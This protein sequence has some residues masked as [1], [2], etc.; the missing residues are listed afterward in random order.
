[1]WSL[2]LS[3]VVWSLRLSPA[4]DPKSIPL[5]DP[6]FPGG[7]AVLLC[8]WALWLWLVCLRGG[9]NVAWR[10]CRCS[11]LIKQWKESRTS[12]R[13]PRT[14]PQE[15]ESSARP[16]YHCLAKTSAT[17]G[18]K[19]QGWCKVH[20]GEEERRRCL[21]WT[22]SAWRLQRGG[23]AWGSG[24]KGAHGD[25]G[26]FCPGSGSISHWQLHQPHVGCMVSGSQGTQTQLTNRDNYE[27]W[28]LGCWH[29]FTVGRGQ[30]YFR[31]RR[32]LHTD[33]N[34]RMNETNQWQAVSLLVKMPEA[35]GV[36]PWA[37]RLRPLCHWVISI[38]LGPLQA[39]ANITPQNSFEAQ[40]G[41]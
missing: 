22:Q 8:S 20:Y 30:H 36:D 41:G 1:M 24:W 3:L 9:C 16:D 40:F 25:R 31:R 19:S 26:R 33:R 14:P 12:S 13:K 37:R 5:S 15:L 27:G 10:Q 35:A 17:S 7:L 38:Y 6:P 39:K 34:T 32:D 11:A 4:L 18:G 29:A 23:S 2:D 21:V 28:Q